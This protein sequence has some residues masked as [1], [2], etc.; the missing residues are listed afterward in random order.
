MRLYTL[1]YKFILTFDISV[2]ETRIYI[3]KAKEGQNTFFFSPSLQTAMLNIFIL[4]NYI[5]DG[6]LFYRFRHDEYKSLVKFIIRASE[7]NI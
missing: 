7:I 6:R 2:L 3:F 4:Q 1:R 5:L